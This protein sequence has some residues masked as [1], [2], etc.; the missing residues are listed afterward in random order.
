MKAMIAGALALISTPV[1]AQ[2]SPEAAQAKIKYL[3]EKHWK[4]IAPVDF[5]VSGSGC[6][7]RMARIYPPRT[8]SGGTFPET[9]DV[10]IWNW[11][12]D[13][14][15]PPQG[16]QVSV[17]KGPSGLVFEMA[18][19]AAAREIHAAMTRLVRHCRGDVTAFAS[20]G[21][22]EPPL[23]RQMRKRMIGVVAECL[24]PAKTITLYGNGDSQFI[25]TSAPE[26]VT[27]GRLHLN[28]E[29]GRLTDSAIRLEGRALQSRPIDRFAYLLD[30]KPAGFSVP[31]HDTDTIAGGRY[32]P[33]AG[34]ASLPADLV[35]AM[36]QARQLT[37]IARANGVELARVDFDISEFHAFLWLIDN[38]RKCV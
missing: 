14:V 2:D 3:V 23:V 18:S 28:W 9:R 35:R 24:S 7:T 22:A 8:N 10:R 15:Q 21:A 16:S 26:S 37:V 25:S 5:D 4:P 33:I 27:Y 13:Q 11:A 6:T 38:N 1:Q 17:M 36:R 31:F 30:S 32:S 34:L 20:S 12:T 19:P 29:R